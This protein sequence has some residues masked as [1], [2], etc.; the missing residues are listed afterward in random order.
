MTDLERKS[1]EARKTEE[2]PKR[3]SKEA[4]AAAA[5]TEELEVRVDREPKSKL[6]E[7]VL[8][9]EETLEAAIGADLPW[10]LNP[11]SVA[12][13]PSKSFIVR[14]R[15]MVC[16]GI[17]RRTVDPPRESTVRG[18]QRTSEDTK[19]GRIESHFFIFSVLKNFCFDETRVPQILILAILGSN[20]VMDSCPGLQ[21]LLITHSL[22][23]NFLNLTLLDSFYNGI[24]LAGFAGF[25][26]ERNKSL[27]YYVFPLGL[28]FFYNLENSYFN[29]HT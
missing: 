21:E 22:G 15:D 10:G 4:A 20:H 9:L 7:E 24:L 5:L 14:E 6:R 11:K 29:F 18:E 3:S 16:G 8:L 12:K 23:F 19:N 27:S 17:L 25:K 1:A 2:S 26:K 13:R 28:I